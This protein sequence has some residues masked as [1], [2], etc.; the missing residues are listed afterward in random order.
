MI[1]EQITNIE[2]INDNILK[3]NRFLMPASMQYKIR[4]AEKFKMYK[5]IYLLFYGYMPVEY[6]R[7]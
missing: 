3:G 7:L 2:V 1:W 4:W 6:V 5:I